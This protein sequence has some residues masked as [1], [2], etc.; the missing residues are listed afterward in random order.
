M[1]TRKDYLG[2]ANKIF[3]DFYE[4]LKEYKPG[5]LFR[6]GY[7]FPKVNY[8]FITYDD[9]DDCLANCKIEGFIRITTKLGKIFES[10]FFV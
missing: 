7:Q 1:K 10:S 5:L 4:S 8:I 2:E 3:P 9:G 6:K